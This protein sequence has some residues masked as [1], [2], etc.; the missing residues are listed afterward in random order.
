MRAI[1][2][3]G[4]GSKT[5]PD[6]YLGL[7]EVEMQMSDL[8]KIVQDLCE[9]YGHS[10]I[11]RHEYSVRP[12]E[13]R[14]DEK[15][16]YGSCVIAKTREGEFVLIRMSYVL[17][18]GAAGPDAWSLIC[19]KLEE[20]E[21]F[22]ETAIRETFEETGIAIKITGLY[23]IFQNIQISNGRRWTESYVAVFFGEVISEPD[24]HESPEVI[25][26]RKFIRLPRGFACELGKYYEDLM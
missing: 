9:K 26:V 15:A 4:V 13:F 2:V 11:T 12:N 14:D 19:G 21:S 16:S 20:S 8:P 6:T 17:P 25:E 7:K 23:K 10:E 3:E 24:H 1:R 18:Q 5:T 22:E